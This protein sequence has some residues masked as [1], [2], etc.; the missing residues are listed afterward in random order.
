MWD[1]ESRVELD[2]N[3]SSIISNPSSRVQTPRSSDVDDRSS[4]RQSGISMDS[5]PNDGDIG[6]GSKHPS[7]YYP[8]IPVA[9]RGGVNLPVKMD[10]QLELDSQLAKSLQTSEDEISAKI[11]ANVPS[12]GPS[13]SGMLR[14]SAKDPNE[15]V[16]ESIQHE[17]EILSSIPVREDWHGDTGVGA[18]PFHRNLDLLREAGAGKA[19]S[20][21]SPASQTKPAS[22]Q[23]TP[24]VMDDHR[25]RFSVTPGA[26]PGEHQAPTR[27]AVPQSLMDNNSADG[28]TMMCARQ[29]TE[30]LKRGEPFEAKKCF[31]R[32]L[33]LNDGSVKLRMRIHAQLAQLYLDEKDYAVASDHVQAQL[34]LARELELIQQEC[35][36]LR[37]LS[38]I[39]FQHGMSIDR[40]ETLDEF[41]QVADAGLMFGEALTACQELIQKSESDPKCASIAARSQR[42]MMKVH[43]VLKNQVE[44]ENAAKT[45]LS[46]IRKYGQRR[47]IARAVLSLALL[48]IQNGESG[49]SSWYKKD[50]DE[51]Q[52]LLWEQ[53]ALG[54]EIKDGFIKGKAYYEISKL[55]ENA[56]S[57]AQWYGPAKARQFLRKAQEGYATLESPTTSQQDEIEDIEE[58]LVALEADPSCSIQ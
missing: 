58:R 21:A 17:E 26:K 4:K 12:D 10:V 49:D 34:S 18:K 23:F 16:A 52:E 7:S 39:K 6:S 30:H 44:A 8:P 43:M 2:Q 47:E 25:V 28:R 24:G 57:W 48:R 27:T 11:L 20:Q 19:S 9:Q 41:E 31:E 37:M 13:P 53:A 33:S 45:H 38:M 3:N 50:F 14:A 54:E 51:V 56:G 5:F 36:A 42:D 22:L 29:G 15:V 40:D 46:E 32:G 55:M 35:L 1:M